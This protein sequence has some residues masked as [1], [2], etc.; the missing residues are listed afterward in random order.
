LPGR[1]IIITLAGHGSSDVPYLI[2]SAFEF[3]AHR[4]VKRLFIILDIFKVLFIKDFK[5]SRKDGFEIKN[6]QNKEPS[7][8]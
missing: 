2:K 3:I 8:I 1:S 4:K 5:G 6:K 7:K